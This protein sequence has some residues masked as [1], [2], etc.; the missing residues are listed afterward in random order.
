MPRGSLVSILPGAGL[1]VSG[2]PVQMH[3]SQ[4]LY[5]FRLGAVHDTVGKTVNPASADVV[6]ESRV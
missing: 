1:P 6:F 3:D 2:L 4:D 5:A